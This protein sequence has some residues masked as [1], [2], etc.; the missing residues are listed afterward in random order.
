MTSPKDTAED[1]QA[2]YLDAVRKSQAAVLDGLRSW[3][4]TIQQLVPQAGTWPATEQLPNPTELV[5]SVF[6]FAQQLLNAQR[7]F[8]HGVLG[9][10]ASV[11]ERAREET[12]RAGQQAQKS[13]KS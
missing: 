9:A 6:D 2:Q 12:S 5:D 7:E 13:T 1:L 8:A 3:T 11:A 4:E 10:T